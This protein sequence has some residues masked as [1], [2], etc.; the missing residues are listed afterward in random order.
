MK[1]SN[2]IKVLIVGALIGVINGFFGGGGGMVCVP[3]LEKGMNLSNKQAHATT[4]AV[5]LPISIFSAIVWGFSSTAD[6]LTIVWVGIGSVIGGI[7]GAILLKKIESKMVKIIFSLI[8][9]AA[10]IR[11]IFW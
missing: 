1:K 7:T 9:L 5:I 2:F 3:I 8:V 11:E 4:I 6:S 10:G